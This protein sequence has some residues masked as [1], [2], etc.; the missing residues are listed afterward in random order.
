M[1][2]NV[3]VV[4]DETPICQ[5]LVYCISKAS[6]DYVVSSASNGEEA[7]EIIL[8]EKPDIVFT[9]IRMPGMDGLELMKRTLEVLPFT[10]F[11]ILTNYAEFHYARQAVSLGAREYFLKSEL[12]ASDLEKLLSEVLASKTKKRTEKVDDVFLS[13]CIDLYNFYAGHEQPGNA[14]RF[15]EKQGM[16]ADVPYQLL[17]VTG[18]SRPEEWQEVAS[19]ALALMQNSAGKAYLAAAS[20]KG[21]DY[22]VVQ[23]AQGRNG[24]IQDLVAALSH[25]GAV[26]ASSVLQSRSDIAQGLREAALARQAAFFD[27][28][29][30][31]LFFYPKIARRKPLNRELLLDRRETILTHI[32]QR[33]YQEA[34]KLLDSWFADI[35]AP[36]TEDIKWAVDCCR[37]MVLSVEELYHQELKDRPAEME[38]QQSVRECSSRCIQM[39]RA[40]DRHHAARCSPSIAAAIEYIHAHYHEE[41]SMAEV[42]RQIYRSPEYFSRQFKEEVGENFNTYLTLYRLDRAQE[43]LDRT[44][45]RIAEIAERVGYVTP[46]Y[47]SRIYKKYRG[48]TPEQ[49]R[50]SKK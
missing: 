42:A 32:T 27:D 46:G 24:Y 7:Y 10:A 37:R 25:R 39:V 40:M 15:W 34:E 23:A 17:C 21:L 36:G 1:K 31:K 14:D 8:R 11:A 30:E 20:E 45:L 26:G 35:S 49:D 29:G 38:V 43:L 4:D 28:L 33:N 48:I 44:D 6:E 12:R 9:D 18:G 50:M 19:A 41:V 13:G 2:L 5:W 47:F 3:M 16:K 22:V